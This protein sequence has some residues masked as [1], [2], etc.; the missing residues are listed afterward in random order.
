M[1]ALT[2]CDKIES[3][4]NAYPQL[5]TILVLMLIG[6]FVAGDWGRRCRNSIGVTVSDPSEFDC[7]ITIQFLIDVVNAMRRS[8]PGPYKHALAHMLPVEHGQDAIST[9]KKAP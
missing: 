4:R 9:H 6:A 8:I 7:W 2:R 5:V 3:E 1:G